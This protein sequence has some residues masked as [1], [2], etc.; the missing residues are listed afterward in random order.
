MREGACVLQGTG[1]CTEKGRLWYSKT[2]AKEPFRYS[3][4]RE[5]LKASELPLLRACRKA[6]LLVQAFLAL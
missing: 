4:K 2:S 6:F 5:S 3:Y 1:A